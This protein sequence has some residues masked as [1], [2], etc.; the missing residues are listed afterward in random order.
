MKKRTL[1]DKAANLLC[2]ALFA[3]HF[4][5]SFFYESALFA[6]PDLTARLST[7]SARY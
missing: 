4:I 1:S 3:L 5:A 7:G 6:A 2:F